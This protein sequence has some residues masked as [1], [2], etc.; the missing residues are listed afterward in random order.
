MGRYTPI[1]TVLGVVWLAG[2]NHIMEYANN[3]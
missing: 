1:F 2:V 3:K